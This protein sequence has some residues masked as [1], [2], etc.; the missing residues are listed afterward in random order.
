[1]SQ[2]SRLISALYRASIESQQLP[3]PLSGPV[4][5]GRNSGYIN[6]SAPEVVDP[7]G[8]GGAAALQ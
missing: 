6:A 8:G 2:S 4:D 1:M 7:G 5:P 3:G